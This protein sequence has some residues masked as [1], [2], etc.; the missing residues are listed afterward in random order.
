M[1]KK[2][3]ENILDNNSLQFL[4]NHSLF[5]I[6]VLESLATFLTLKANIF[7]ASWK[8][9]LIYRGALTFADPWVPPFWPP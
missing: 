6:I 8:K 1:K 3:Q 7:I 2:I 9:F 4:R 5:I